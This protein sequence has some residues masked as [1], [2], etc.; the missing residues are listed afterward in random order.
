MQ[1]RQ[2]LRIHIPND[3]LEFERIRSREHY[4]PQSLVSIVESTPTSNFLDRALP[5]IYAESTYPPLTR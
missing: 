5:I 2:S 1:L 3:I 4:L